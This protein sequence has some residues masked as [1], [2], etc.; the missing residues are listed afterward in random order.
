MKAISRKVIFVKRNHV[1]NTCKQ[2]VYENIYA[3]QYSAVRIN[4]TH[5]NT[6]VLILFYIYTVKFA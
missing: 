5:Q 1:T 4:N 2:A 3:V 6:A